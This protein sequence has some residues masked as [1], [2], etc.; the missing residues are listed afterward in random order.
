[1]D[2]EVKIKVS[3][4]T[5]AHI[6][7]TTRT[8]TCPTVQMNNVA[9]SKVNEVKYLGMHVDRRLTWAKHI[10]MERK[11]LNLRFRKMYWLLG[12]QSTLSSESK[13]LLCKAVIKPI[14]TYGIKL[15]GTALNSNIEIIQRFQS[16]TLRTIL[17]VPWHINNS[18][19]HEVLQ[20]KT[21]KNEMKKI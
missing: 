14:W 12:R 20:V 1:M 4:T 21:V 7:F 16:K 15:W 19:I 13:L 11:Q 2:E 8:L 9:L 3:Q 17:N 6:M 5:L 10:K 18:T